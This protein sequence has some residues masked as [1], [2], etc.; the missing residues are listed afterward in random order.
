VQREQGVTT[1]GGVAPSWVDNYLCESD[2]R[3]VISR[4]SSIGPV[5]ACLT[6]IRHGLIGVFIDKALENRT[7]ADID[8]EHQ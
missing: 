7:D 1:C 4:V 5:K 8:I 2:T 6:L 3:L